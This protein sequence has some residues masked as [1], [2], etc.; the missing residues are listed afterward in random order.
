V[1][2]DRQLF[3]GVAG[4]R[5][6]LY[7]SDFMTGILAALAERG[8]TVLL[9]RSNRLDATFEQLFREVEQQASNFDLDLRFF[10]QTHPQYGDSEDVQQELT[11]AA[12]RDLIS[13]DNPEFQVVRFKIKARDANAFL[14]DL[15]GS[16]E[17]YERLAGRFLELYGETLS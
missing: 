3:D 9:N 16:P 12:R 14:R 17:L 5:T 8:V 15:P 13:L 7:L 6:P 11:S 10:I 2:G 4:G 1:Q